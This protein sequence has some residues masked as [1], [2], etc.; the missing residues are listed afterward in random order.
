MALFRIILSNNNMKSSVIERVSAFM[1]IKGMSGRAFANTIGFNYSTFNNYM[2]G[3]RAGMDVALVERIAKSFRELDVEWLITGEGEMMK[4]TGRSKGSLTPL[5]YP[6]KPVL[7]VIDESCSMKDVF[8][9]S[10][11]EKGFEYLSLPINV[12]YD[13]SIRATGDS[14]VNRTRP[15]KSIKSGDIVACR[16]WKSKNHIRWGEVYALSTDDGIIVKKIEKSDKEDAI[17]CVSYNVEENYQPYE[18]P[19]SEIHDMA[20]VVGVISVSVWN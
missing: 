6:L 9:L 2:T 5:K 18:L 15:E 8:S 4:G 14:M 7:D 17:L 3:R 11:S 10:L 20:L 16:V 12:V 1:E 13:F 19:M